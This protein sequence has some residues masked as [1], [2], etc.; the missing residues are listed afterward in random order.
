MKNTRETKALSFKPAN[1]SE[2]AANRS[3]AAFVIVSITIV[4]ST[5]GLARYCYGL[6]LPYIQQDFDLSRDVLGLIASVSYVGYLLATGLGVIATERFGPR[7]PIAVGG[8]FAAFGMALIGISSSVLMLAVG[9]FLAGISPGLAY[10][11]MSEAVLQAVRPNRRERTY[12]WINSGTSIGIMVA[13]PIALWAGTQ[14]RTAWLIFASLAFV[15][16]LASLWAVPRL[17]AFQSSATQPT[18]SLSFLKRRD[19][20]ALF[21]ST[22]FIGIISSV[23]W[24]FSVDLL[25]TEGGQSR[26][27]SIAFWVIIGV[28]GIVGG[29]VGD[30]LKTIGLRHCHALMLL[31]LAISIGVLPLAETN[32]IWIYGSA[33]LFGATFIALTAVLGIWSIFVFHDRPAAGFGTVFFLLSLGQL[34]GPAVTGYAADLVGLGTLFYAASIS[35]LGLFGLLA[36]THT[37]TMSKDAG[38]SP[39]S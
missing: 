21:I 26:E 23:Y 10:P 8:A 20:R 3:P 33:I 39:L 28:A 31:S 37:N 27:I 24:T 18:I 5:Y 16:A 32:G 7:V 36:E 4:A 38:A 2:I 12:T 9:V 19:A 1:G 22:F 25:V 11:P 29:F 13:A 30:L 35:C 6:F 17:R 15:A 14:W 34:I